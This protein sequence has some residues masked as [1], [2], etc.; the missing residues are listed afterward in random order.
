MLEHPF[1]MQSSGLAAAGR[2]PWRGSWARSVL[3]AGHR[4]KPEAVSK[5]RVEEQ[6]QTQRET[7]AEFHSGERLS[8]EISQ[9]RGW[10]G[11]SAQAA[12]NRYRNNVCK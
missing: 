1:P 6:N 3:V 9:Q 5:R 7:T 11:S 4:G 8:K 10:R 12:R 2:W